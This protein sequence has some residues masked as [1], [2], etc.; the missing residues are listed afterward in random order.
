MRSLVRG[1]VSESRSAWRKGRV[2]D[3]TAPELVGHASM[4]AAVQRIADDGVADGAQV[5]ADLVRAPGVDGDPAQRHAA[6]VSRPGDAGDGLAGAAGAGRHLLAMPG[7]AADRGVDALALL[8]QTPDQRHVLL[9][10]L[11]VVELAGQF[12][13]RRVVLGHHHDAAGALVEPM[14]DPGTDRAADPAQ[15]LD[16]MEQRV[17]ERSVRSASRG[18]D[19]HA[20]RLVDDDDI[21]VVEED[22]ERDVL[23]LRPSRRTRRAASLRPCRPRAAA[24]W[25]WCA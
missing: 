8:D 22:D 2:S 17:H 18:M 20:G 11:A 3:C 21:G 16:V 25:P 19:H 15:V 7:V 10:H 23:S 4:R 14:D 1:C 5:H 6:E 12:L 24:R 13:V 9:F